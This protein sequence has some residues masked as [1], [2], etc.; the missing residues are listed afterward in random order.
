[1]EDPF[2]FG[3]PRSC[4]VADQN[5]WIYGLMQDAYLWAPDLPEI[6]P[7]EY[8][9]PGETIAAL[10]VDPDRWSRVGDKVKTEKL[11]EEGKLISLGFRTR[12]NAAGNLTVSWVSAD[13]SALAAGMKR[14]DA[15][16][17]IGGFTIAQ[18]DEDDAW[19]DVYGSDEPGV[20]VTVEFTRPG[21]EPTRATLVKEWLDIETVP[22]HGVID[23]DGSAV[24]YL[25]FSTFVDTAPDR[26]DAVF[27]EFV[28]AG[29]DRVIVDLRYNGG[30]RVSVA[31]QLV[32]LLVGDV[33][34][35]ET[36]YAIEYGPGLADQDTAR[37][38]SRRDGSIRAPREV[39]FITTGSTL[40]ASELVINAVR[41]HVTTKLV[42]DTTGG[43]PVGSH[44]W[45]FCDKVAQPITFRLLNADGVG[46][47]FDGIAADCIEAD[48]LTRELGDVREGALAHALH[49]LTTGECQPPPPQRPEIE[50]APEGE[51]AAPGTGPR[52]L[53]PPVHD[54]IEGM[55]GFF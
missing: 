22:I 30:G 4:E 9:S 27:E 35:G 40:S 52:L 16:E 45:S 41:P 28:A 46:D 39:V 8:E 21:G 36:N 37:D 31:R 6:D 10:R 11:F 7:L 17:T 51:D 14:G 33:A 20:T 24:G 26:L 15:V 3:D 25:M 44:Q 5:E 50:D 1:M 49:L 48:D 29:V 18:I 53:P 13:S 19:G 34:D 43:K 54:E 55:R 38:V 2:D 12:R 32:D 47:Y 42:G 23:V